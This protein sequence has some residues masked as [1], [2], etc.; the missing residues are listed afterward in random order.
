MCNPIAGVEQ[1]VVGFLCEAG[2][3]V[4]RGPSTFCECTF[5]EVRVTRQD[6][7]MESDVSCVVHVR[8]NIT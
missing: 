6:R 8:R 4:T 5:V 1:Q 7:Q 3:F 2:R